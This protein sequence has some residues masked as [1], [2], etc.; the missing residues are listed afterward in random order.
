MLWF[1]VGPATKRRTLLRQSNQP[2]HWSGLN[3]CRCALCRVDTG[4]V[5]LSR[6][7]STT[8][9]CAST[10]GRTAVFCLRIVLHSRHKYGRCPSYR[11][12]TS[13]AYRRLCVACI[14]TGRRRTSHRGVHGRRGCS[15]T[16]CGLHTCG[17]PLRSQWRTRKSMSAVW[18]TYPAS[19]YSDK[20]QFPAAGL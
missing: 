3:C 15:E 18:F 11:Q 13:A 5:A 6:S 7:A 17:R 20:P 2:V 19:Q 1:S 8:V 12:R 9:R 10:S 16:L 4:S 14:R